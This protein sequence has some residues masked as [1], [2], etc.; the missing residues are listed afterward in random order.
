MD[1]FYLPHEVLTSMFLKEVTIRLNEIQKIN[2]INWYYWVQKVDVKNN[3]T[4]QKRVKKTP[5]FRGLRTSALW[6][7]LKFIF[8]IYILIWDYVEHFLSCSPEWNGFWV[9]L[10]YHQG[11]DHPLGPWVPFHKEI[12]SERWCLC[13]TGVRFP[14]TLT[15]NRK[16]S[17]FR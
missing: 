14:N 11:D 10:F 9:E 3:K 8:A 4:K 5:L 2:L 12:L 1:K 17:S 16:R 7:K 6:S 13:E 15:S